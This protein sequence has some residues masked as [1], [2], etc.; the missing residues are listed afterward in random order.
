MSLYKPVKVA[1]WIFCHLV[2]RVRARGRANIPGK[3]PFILLSN[4]QS[5]LDPIFIQAHCPREVH[6]MTKSTQFAQPFFRWVIPRLHGFPTRRYKVDPQA[7]RISLRLLAQGHGVGIYPEG[8]RSW[9]GALQP[10]RRGAIRLALKAGVPVIPCGIS[11]SYGVLPRWS[12]RPRR[13]RVTIHFGEPIVFGRHDHKA[14]REAVLE[15]TRTL[16]EEA[17]SRAIDPEEA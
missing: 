1:L 17:L 11:G 9:D 2:A 8:E 12:R 10:L 14:E 7:V 13:G 16:L 6:S 5:I 15:R 3:G 4:H